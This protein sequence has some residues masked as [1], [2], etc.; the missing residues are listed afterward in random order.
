I[1]WDNVDGA[2][3]YVVYRGIE[4]YGSYSSVGGR[5]TSTSLTDTTVSASTTY[6]YSVKSINACGGTAE[7]LGGNVVSVTTLC[8]TSV[9]TN[10]IVT[11]RSSSSLEVSWNAVNSAV[12]YSVYRSSTVTGTYT[13]L[14][15]VATNSFTDTGLSNLTP[16]FYKITAKTELCDDSRQSAYGSGTTQ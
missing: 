14:G 5:V 13:L 2:A 9:P 16:Y 15:K 10:I 7:N 12:S 8:E 11:P 6:Y 4:R 3:S 1:T